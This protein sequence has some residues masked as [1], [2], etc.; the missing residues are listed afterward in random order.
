M[1]DKGSFAYAFKAV[2]PWWL[3]LVVCYIGLKY[4]V[5]WHAGFLPWQ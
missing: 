4:L 2:L 5:L 1:D 3:L